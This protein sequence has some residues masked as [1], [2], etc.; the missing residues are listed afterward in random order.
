[1]SLMVRRI[2]CRSGRVESSETVG[3]SPP[4]KH[5]RHSSTVPFD[6][7]GMRV[8][9]GPVQGARAV[10]LQSGSPP[11]P[12]KKMLPGISRVFLQGLDSR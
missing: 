4:E 6:G 11:K 8:Y 2:W 3:C 7:G 9:G 10:R 12:K 1:M 5:R